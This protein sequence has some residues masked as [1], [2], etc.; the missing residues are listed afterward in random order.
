VSVTPE[1]YVSK[2]AVQDTRASKFQ[3][4]CNHSVGHNLSTMRA[5]NE[6]LI[7]LKRLVF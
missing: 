5:T 7:D 3:K 6:N 2:L 4:I 1:H